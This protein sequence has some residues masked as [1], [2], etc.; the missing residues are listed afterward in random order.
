MCTQGEKKMKKSIVY[1]EKITIWLFGIFA[2]D[3]YG[4]RPVVQ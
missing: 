2:V 4:N 1:I 3:D